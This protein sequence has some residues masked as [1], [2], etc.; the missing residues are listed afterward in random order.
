LSATAELGRKVDS[1]VSVEARSPS[2]GLYHQ[3]RPR[4]INWHTPP[5]ASF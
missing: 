5:G 4:R 3:M 1:Q 2:G